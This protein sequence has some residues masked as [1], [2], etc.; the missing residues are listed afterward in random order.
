[1]KAIEITY[2]ITTSIVSLMMIYSSYA[3]L[4][5]PAMQQAFQHLPAPAVQVESR[6]AGIG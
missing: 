4:T 1:M 6:K 2:W 3:Y 5:Q